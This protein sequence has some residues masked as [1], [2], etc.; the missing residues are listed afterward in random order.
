MKKIYKTGW[1]TIINKAGH[2]QKVNYK[3]SNFKAKKLKQNLQFDT[4]RR[5]WIHA[6]VFALDKTGFG[7]IETRKGY[8]SSITFLYQETRGSKRDE[9][10]RLYIFTEL[11]DVTEKE[12]KNAIEMFFDKKGFWFPISSIYGKELNAETTKT[13]D[14]IDVYFCDFLQNGKVVIHEEIKRKW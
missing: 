11:P 9:E 8:R 6:E 4:S 1:H 5:V 7:V 10:F 12:L 3:P 2:K 13:P 14:K